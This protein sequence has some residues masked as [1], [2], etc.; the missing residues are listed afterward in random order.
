VF[1][2]DS[3]LTIVKTSDSVD[4][5]QAIKEKVDAEIARQR[6][7]DTGGVD[8]NFKNFWCLSVAHCCAYCTSVKLLYLTTLCGV[9][10]SEKLSD[11]TVLT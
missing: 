5:L 8:G 3:F 10:R 9:I 7:N 1:T 6:S 4:E 11:V 2:S